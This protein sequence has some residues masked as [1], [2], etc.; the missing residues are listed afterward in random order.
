M[1][2]YVWIAEYKDGTRLLEYKDNVQSFFKDIDEDNLKR[3]IVVGKNGE[4]SVDMETAEFSIFGLK[5]KSNTLPLG[6]YRLV[7]FKRHRHDFS[8]EGEKHT[9]QYVFG[10]QTTVNETNYQQLF[11]IQEDGSV[12]INGEK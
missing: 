7:W 11:W 12:H 6:K 9:V 10:V 3:F 2:D 8:P 5:I 1:P 4:C